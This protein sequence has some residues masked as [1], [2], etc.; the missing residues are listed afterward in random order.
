MVERIEM[1]Q[2]WKNFVLNFTESAIF[3]NSIDN[4]LTG[5]T[6]KITFSPKYY[7][8]FFENDFTHSSRKCSKVLL[9]YKITTKSRTE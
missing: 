1:V 4:T 5:E 9:S 3:K 2:T 7:T 6:V 8:G